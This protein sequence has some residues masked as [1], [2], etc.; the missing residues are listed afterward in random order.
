MLSCTVVKRIIFIFLLVFLF[1]GGVSAKQ[2][3]KVVYRS[4][5]NAVKLLPTGDAFYRELFDAIDGAKDFICSEYYTVANDS[6]GNAFLSRLARKVSEGVKVYLLIDAYGSFKFDDKPLSKELVKEWGEKGLGIEIFHQPLVGYTLPRNHRKLTIVDGKTAFIGGMNVNDKYVKGTE[7]LGEVNDLTV[8]LDGPAAYLFIDI[9]RED[10]HCGAKRPELDLGDVSPP[11][12]VEGGTTLEILPT[13]GLCPKPNVKNY[14]VEIIDGATKSIRLVNGYFMPCAPVKRA[15][16]RAA[17][18]DVKIDI[19][20]GETTDLPKILHDHPFN[21]AG[22]L[23]KKENITLHIYKGGFFHEKAMSVDGEKLL[24]GSA[25][26]D[27]LS[28]I[29]N[30]E[31]DIILYNEE[32]TAQYDKIF[33]SYFVRDK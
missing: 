23:D 3:Q 28:L 4:E 2:K 14:Y 9:F 22:R 31:I 32:Y 13:T 21:V 19:L 26:L 25:N 20:I 6:I 33:D 5:G 1:A 16:K 15:L 12:P 11:S 18:R 24:V 17:K 7:E 10:W 8:R 29:F 27:W 30:R